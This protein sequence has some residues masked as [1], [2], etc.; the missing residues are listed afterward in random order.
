MSLSCLQPNANFGLHPSVA[1]DKSVQNVQKC[2]VFFLLSCVVSY[3]HCIKYSKI[4]KRNVMHANA[5]NILWY[6]PSL[7]VSVAFSVIVS[8][9]WCEPLPGRIDTLP[10]CMR[11]YRWI[12]GKDTYSMSRSFFFFSNNHWWS[13]IY[14]CLNMFKYINDQYVGYT[15]VTTVTRITLACN[16]HSTDGAGHWR[17]Q[18]DNKHNIQ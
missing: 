4:T 17:N 14:L 10:P 8:Y 6:F 11:D 7:S 16:W 3:L 15:L 13:R 9:S 12:R 5:T 1:L 18:H 2:H